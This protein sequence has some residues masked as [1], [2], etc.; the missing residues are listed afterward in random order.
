[1]K[2]IIWIIWI[3]ALKKDKI[4]FYIK[5]LKSKKDEINHLNENC[6]NIR[7]IHNL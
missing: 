2:L 1:M 5:E 3:D 6:K 4:Y 7:L